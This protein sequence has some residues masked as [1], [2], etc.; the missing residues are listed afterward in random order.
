MENKQIPKWVMVWG[1]LMALLPTGFSLIAYIDPM[2]CF[3][4]EISSDEAVIFAG[5]FGL[6]VA[7]NVAEAAVTFIALGFRSV[8]MLLLAF[9]L[10]MITDIFDGVHKV[11]SGTMNI[12]FA[13]DASILIV[14]C[15]LA[16]FSLQKIRKVNFN[17]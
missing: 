7:R 11:Y 2:I 16:I 4:Q 5:A 8:D 3:S 17:E 9:L 1:F 6:Y 12:A 15:S 14:G 13:V 10:R